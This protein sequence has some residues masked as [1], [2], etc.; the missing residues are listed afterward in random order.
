M[1][2]NPQSI[3]RAVTHNRFGPPEDVLTTRPSG[4]RDPG[5]GELLIRVFVRPVHP[6]D[7][8]GI[9]G[10]GAGA[11][12]GARVPGLEGMG[13]VA[14]SGEGVTDWR[15][16]ARVAFFPVQGAWSDLVIA[17]AELCVPLPD[18]VSDAVGSLALVNPITVQTLMREVQ[19]AWGKT[20]RPFVQ[21]AAGS[22]VGKILTAHAARHGYPLVN[23]VRSAEGAAL[24][25]ERFPSIPTIS[26]SDHDW[27][28]KVDEAL[29]GR[30]SVVVDAV[31]G[32]GTGPLLDLLVDGGT[33][34]VYGALAGP[35]M[36]LSAAHVIGRGLQVSGVTIG[37]WLTTRTAEERAQDVAGAISLASEAPELFE[38]AQT[39][40]LADFL[41][42]IEHAQRPGKVGTVLLGSP[43]TR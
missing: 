36:A 34:V 8:A 35:S 15:D 14:A 3:A 26:T 18:R 2:Q 20:A 31:G 30:A 24:L 13:V 29:G 27:R 28:Q 23:L 22:S 40:D 16:G 43:G 1:S 11:T 41:T 37:R 33:L 7:I 32:D 21:T 25:A 38:V 6:G 9:F 10:P 19:A 4:V 12:P 42:A 39:Y 17:P 5:P